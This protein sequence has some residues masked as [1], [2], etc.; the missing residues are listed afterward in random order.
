MIPTGLEALD[1]R[2]GGLRAGGLYTVVGPSAAGKS[3]LGLHFAV[4]G[5]E[6]NEPTVLITRDEPAMIDSRAMFI[7][8]SAGRLTEHPRLRLV[9]PPAILPSPAGVGPGDALVLWLTE[10]IGTPTAYRI[11]VD[12]ESLEGYAV[13]SRVL[14][15]ELLRF[16]ERA[17]AT[18]VALVR[19]D[20]GNVP[21]AGHAPVFDRAAGVFRLQMTKRGER[22]FIFHT[23]PTGS[24]RTEP[25]SFTLRTGA[26]FTEELA[27]A[28]P[29]LAP[30]DRRKVMVLDELGA[31]PVEVLAGLE[32]LYDVVQLRS[33][34]GALKELSA[35]KYGALVVVVDPYDDV[36][37]LDLVFALR[38][39]GNAAPIVFIAP[40]PGLRSTTRSRGLRV[41][42]DDFFVADL[43]PAE[44]IERIQ[45]AWLRGSHRRTGLSQIGQI[46]QPMNADATP[47]PMSE[48]E[49]LQAMSTLLAEQPPL[50]FCYLEFM[51]PGSMPELVWPALRTRVRI[52]DGD[53]VGVLSNQ[54]F[55]CVLDRITPE[56]T[57]RV[58]ERIRTAHPLLQGLTDLVVI[59]SPMRADEIK[60]RLFQVPEPA[61]G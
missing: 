41:G 2:L 11:V 49:L 17:N 26:G 20:D 58:I 34:A 33:A 54:R 36:R 56:Q 60:S 40:T 19:S 52:G 7:G 23:A 14:L 51:V 43:P 13:D 24:F 47:R 46:A 6:R 16:L 61:L 27:L 22:T 31:L 44:I 15:G 38:K 48:A 32:R 57:N 53:I 30:E 1:N 18:T 29:D 5:L 21:R 12:I 28:V 10:Q 55:A 35:G 4:T 59:P 37:S 45:I 42:G 9:R 3:V 50:F 25:F 39:E 8:Y